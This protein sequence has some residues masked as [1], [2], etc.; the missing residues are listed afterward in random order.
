MPH[1]FLMQRFAVCVAVASMFIAGLSDAQASEGAKNFYLLGSNASMA[2][3]VPPPGTTV[4]NYD[5]YYRG[6]AS[7]RG[8]TGVL[9]N[10]GGA[11]LD[12]EADVDVD[13]NIFIKLP[14]ALWVSP[15]KVLGGAAGVGV[16]VP[17]GWQD[18][19][20][21]LDVLATLTLPDGREF[22]AGDRF[23]INDDTFN[24]GDP[25]LLAFLGWNRGNWHWKLQGMLNVPIGAYDA[26][27]V[28]N[29]GF[30]YWAFDASAA[31]TWLDP[32]IGWEASAYTG[33]TFNAENPATDYKSGT[34][35]HLDFALMKHFSKRVAAGLVGYH[36][37]QITGDSGSGAR[38]GPFKGQVTA[39][40][41]AI[42]YN[43]VIRS[44]PVATSLRWYHEFD[45]KNRLEGDAVYFQTTIP[46][47]VSQR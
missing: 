42:N 31:A 37:Q 26:D 21:D 1:H 43:T 25:V 39:I 2:G 45:T 8:A 7:G 13:A 28:A 9:L 38:L 4:V 46:L 41:P 15:R 10:E 19:S 12:L 32:T 6:D 5:Y 20:A 24:F 29:M 16:L 11:R 23:S 33:L 17:V 14:G 30:N 22:T 18:I 40:G 44:I 27:N 47:G 36:Y 3:A 35:F 34:Q